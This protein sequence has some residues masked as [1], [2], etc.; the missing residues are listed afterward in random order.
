MAMAITHATLSASDHSMQLRKAVIASTIGTAIGTT[1]S[2]MARLPGL[3]SASSTFP[4][5]MH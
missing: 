2:F 3:F 5:K 1:S 4:T